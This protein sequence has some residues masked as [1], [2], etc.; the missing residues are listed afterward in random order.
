VQLSRFLPPQNP[1]PDAPLFI[2]LPGMDGTGQLLRPQVAD[3]ERSFDIRR[4]SIP[5]DDLSDWDMMAANIADLIRAELGSEMP[6][7]ALYLCGESF[8]GCLAL[9]L[10]ILAPE[11]CD[12]LILVNP[13]S[14]FQ[15][16]TWIRLVTH[17][18]R[19]LPAN[20]YPLSCM[21]LLP[22][23]ATLSRI[24]SNDGALLLNVMQS[25]RFD[26]AMWRISMLD[27]FD[28]TVQQIQQI[29]QPTLIISSGNDRLLPS[30]IEGNMLMQQIPR[31]SLHLIPQGGHAV[32]LEREVNL[33]SILDQHGFLEQIAEKSPSG[34]PAE[35]KMK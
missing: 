5:V 26:S 30:Q 25:V 12:R 9:K 33:H 18:L 16:K 4:L 17:F 20:L 19:Y 14:S 2:Y 31:S 13:A 3:L 1:Q 6:R 28:A 7:R 23:L 11:L 10:A 35:S 32:L 29:Q 22:L 24:D 8:G 27:R 15:R 21:A 34:L